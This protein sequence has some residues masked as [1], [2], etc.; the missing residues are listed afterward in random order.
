MT[1]PPEEQEQ[2]IGKVSHF[3]DKIGVMAV[4]LTDEL[5]VGERI[6]VTG[7]TTDFVAVVESMQIE[8]ENVARAG[9]GA[10]VGIRVGEKARPGD[11]VYRAA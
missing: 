10:S 4:E 11:T 7:H 8:H 6:H 3:Y 9:A 1:Q 5:A 2:P